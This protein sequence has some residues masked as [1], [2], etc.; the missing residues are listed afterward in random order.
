MQ[1]YQLALVEY[2][3]WWRICRAAYGSEHILKSPPL[4]CTAFAAWRVCHRHSMK[5]PGIFLGVNARTEGP[6]VDWWS[7]C[8]RL[9][10]TLIFRLG[11]LHN[12]DRHSPTHET[13]EQ[14]L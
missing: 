8:Y 1:G 13:V 12:R 9:G 4:F 14:S 11:R 2:R 3:G 6:G 5:R 10:R 7:F